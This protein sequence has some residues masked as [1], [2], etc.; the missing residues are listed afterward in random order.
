MLPPSFPRL[1]HSARKN[2]AEGREDHGMQFKSRR[3]EHGM[4]GAGII[5][6]DWL[7]VD[8]G[9]RAARFVRQ[10]VRRRKVPV[11]AVF[12]RDPLN[13]T[14]PSIF[15]TIHIYLILATDAIKLTIKLSRF[16]FC[17]MLFTF[18]LGYIIILTDSPEF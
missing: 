2:L 14:S 6:D 5:I 16:Q 12:A 8:A 7:A 3:H 9:Q 13:Y 15:Y 10:K 18:M 11:P 4:L 1:R 17:I